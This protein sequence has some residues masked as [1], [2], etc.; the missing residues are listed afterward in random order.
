MAQVKDQ[1]IKSFT[2]VL[3][4]ILVLVVVPLIEVIAVTPVKELQCTRRPRS[5]A[6]TQ[7]ITIQLPASL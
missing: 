7:D 4:V 5:H 3:V 6:A 2:P 1:R